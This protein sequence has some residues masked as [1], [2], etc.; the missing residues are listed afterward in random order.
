ML[1][2]IQSWQQ[3]FCVNIEIRTDDRF[4]ATIDEFAR[5]AK[6]YKQLR[7]E[8]FY[9]YMHNN[10]KIEVKQREGNGVMIVK[11]VKLLILISRF[12]LHIKTHQMI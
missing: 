6:D 11:I 5:W 4:L 7:I 10:T 3:D 2:D 9:R 8:Y 12:L 1:Q